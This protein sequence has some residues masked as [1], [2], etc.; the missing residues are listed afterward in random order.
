MTLDGSNGVMHG[1]GCVA[2]CTG[3]SHV[4][5]QDDRAQSPFS[6]DSC[7]IEVAI[8]PSFRWNAELP[9]SPTGLTSAEARPLPHSVV[10]QDE[11]YVMKKFG[12]KEHM[13]F[14]G[15]F[16]GYGPHGR[17]IA[18]EVS[19]R[20]P[21]KLLEVLRDRHAVARLEQGEVEGTM[22]DVCAQVDSDLFSSHGSQSIDLTSNSGTTAC[23]AL[24]QGDAIHVANVGD[25][26][27]VL[28]SKSSEKGR[29]QTTRLSA[30]ATPENPIEAKRILDAGGEIKKCLEKNGRCS[31]KER[32]FKECS[33]VN[34]PG[35]TSTR[36]IGDKTAAEIGII[37]EPTVCTH[38][39]TS[40]DL[41]I[42]L[43]SKGVWDVMDDDVAGA[44]V[45]SFV[46]C[47]T[48]SVGCAEA[49]TLEAQE[50]WKRQHYDT[51]VDDIS[52]A[53]AHLKPLPAINLMRGIDIPKGI[54]YAP[55][56]NEEANSIAAGRRERTGF[57][58]DPATVE[59]AHYFEDIWTDVSSKLRSISFGQTQKL[60]PQRSSLTKAFIEANEDSNYGK[61]ND[62]GDYV[63][64][65]PP[66][67]SKSSSAFIPS[68]AIGVPE[69]SSGMRIHTTYQ[70]APAPRML[71]EVDDEEL[72]PIRKAHP[73]YATL[74]HT[75]SWE[76][77]LFSY[78]S[79][80]DV[81]LVD[82]M[83]TPR[84][85]DSSISAQREERPHRGELR[86][87]GKVHRGI[88]CSYSSVG[89]ASHGRISTDS[90]RQSD[91]SHGGRFGLGYG[92]ME[93]SALAA[94]LRGLELTS[95]SRVKSLPIRNQIG[96]SMSMP[97]M[98]HSRSTNSLAKEASGEVPLSRRCSGKVYVFRDI[99]E[100]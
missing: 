72:R 39:L 23:F 53:I 33:N 66:L 31:G 71:N 3:G 2:G 37:S 10:C 70:S 84:S 99:N 83:D 11:V 32:V 69:P 55:C 92:S 57:L 51:V 85:S 1:V 80:S 46:H 45:E 36:A 82:G 47:R 81:W 77:N 64:S 29:V 74:S 96:V 59:P 38:T 41:F 56:S 40:D 78:K 60:N 54:A 34:E 43:A 17:E 27:C 20:V 28:V 16:D 97:S 25:S 35:L 58:T 91:S 44:F 73:S 7:T 75:F 98:A 86:H 9:N 76:K 61:Q 50:M 62:G 15:V 22:R 13:I 21:E 87:E 4:M 100:I 49:L 89:L 90:E 5:Q 24:I 6:S 95:P 65:D 26:R 14:L 94:G 8:R 93:E 88:P 79:Q 67:V 63:D 42:I 12:E 30:D 68:Q 18:V 48:N 19:K 52:C